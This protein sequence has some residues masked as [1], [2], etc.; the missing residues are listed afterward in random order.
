MKKTSRGKKGC[1]RI[2]VK[3]ATGTDHTA[4]RKTMAAMPGVMNIIQTFP[5]ET[6][7]ELASLYLLEVEPSHIKAALREL[8]VLPEVEYAEE[9][10]P[11]KL[12]RGGAD[13]RAEHLSSPVRQRCCREQEPS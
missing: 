11:R 3:L 13:P 9:A 5:D 8:R 4:C 10:A 1:G 2:N 6:D 12:I 7:Q